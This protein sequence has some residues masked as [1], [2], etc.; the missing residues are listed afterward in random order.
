MVPELGNLF[1]I[2]EKGNITQKHTLIRGV[3][4]DKLVWG[5]GLFRTAFIDPTFYDNVLKVN[6]KGLLLYEQ[7]SPVL[8]FS[9]V[10]TPGRT[11]IEPVHG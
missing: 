8:G 3:F 11:E 10:S 6:E 9:P 2:Y 4:K 1:Q 5:G 7:P